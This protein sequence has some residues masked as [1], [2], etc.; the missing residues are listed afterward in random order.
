VLALVVAR[1]LR[2]GFGGAVLDLVLLGDQIATLVLGGVE[3]LLEA[4]Q[5]HHVLATISVLVLLEVI[6]ARVL[7]AVTRV[8]EHLPPVVL[9]LGVE[10][11]RLKAG[12][13]VV[14]KVDAGAPVL[15]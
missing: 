9:G 15:E 13:R 7:R 2:R 10:D 1:Q 4:H 3:L 14:L 6:P 5:A 11:V 8:D 12:S